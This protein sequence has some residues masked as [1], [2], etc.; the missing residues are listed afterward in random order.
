MY[1][2]GSTGGGYIGDLDNIMTESG[3]T[4]NFLWFRC[5]KNATN[6]PSDFA[7]DWCYGLQI[8]NLQV[9]WRYWGM[10]EKIFYRTKP[11]TTVG[12]WSEWKTISTT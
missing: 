6:K 3:A 8:V 2:G 1:D 4:I 12:T 10:N 7:S 9:V 5:N 11:N